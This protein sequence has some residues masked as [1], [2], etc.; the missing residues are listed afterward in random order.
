MLWFERIV[1]GGGAAY[2]TRLERVIGVAILCWLAL[3]LPLLLLPGVEIRPLLTTVERT[4]LHEAS[5]TE[6]LEPESASPMRRALQKLA[7]A[8]GLM[9]TM[10]DLRLRPVQPISTAFQSYLLAM[11]AIGLCLIAL[12][13]LT[14]AKVSPIMQALLGKITG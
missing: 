2:G 12:M 3:A 14:L 13:A 1:W 7:Y 4:S 6:A 5:K 10:P 9:F 8:F 11:R